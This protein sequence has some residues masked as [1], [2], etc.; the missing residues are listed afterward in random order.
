MLLRMAYK[1]TTGMKKVLHVMLHFSNKVKMIN[2]SRVCYIY[3]VQYHTQPIYFAVFYTLLVKINAYNSF[4]LNLH[5]LGF[6]GGFKSCTTIYF[7]FL[8]HACFSSAICLN[9]SNN[10]KYITPVR[11][12]WLPIVCAPE[13]QWEFTQETDGSYV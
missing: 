12:G 3:Y 10:W 8:V 13:F 5:H 9:M 11:H 2:R 4:S 6:I 1:K 7:V